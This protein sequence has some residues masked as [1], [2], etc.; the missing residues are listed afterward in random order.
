MHSARRY[1]V[2]AHHCCLPRYH[3]RVTWPVPVRGPLCLGA[4]RYYGMGLFAAEESP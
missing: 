2:G 3:V 1:V 4:G